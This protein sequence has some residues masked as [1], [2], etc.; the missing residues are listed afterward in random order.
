[1][2]RTYMTPSERAGV[3]EQ[4]AHGIRRICLEGISGGEQRRFSHVFAGD[5]NLSIGRNGRGAEA[6]ADVR[7]ALAVDLFAGCDV[8]RIEHAI[9]VS[10]LTVWNS[11][12]IKGVGM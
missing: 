7:H 9:V 11:V 1:M 6:A 12:I 2:K 5:I 8:I 4:F 10:R 3:H